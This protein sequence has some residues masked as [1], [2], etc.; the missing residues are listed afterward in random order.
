MLQETMSVEQPVK[1]VL[2]NLHMLETNHGFNW[3]NVQINYVAF[4][5]HNYRL[6]KVC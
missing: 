6:K 4:I 3:K 5:I 2:L 1:Q